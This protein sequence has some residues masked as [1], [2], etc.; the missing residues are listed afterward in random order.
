MLQAT[1]SVPEVV[2]LLHDY[3][4]GLEVHWRLWFYGVERGGM[5]CG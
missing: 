3:T 4:T 1:E 2:F 5:R